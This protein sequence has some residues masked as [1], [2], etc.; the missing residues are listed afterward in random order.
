MIN[1]PI[2]AG[3]VGELPA[4]ENQDAVN[5]E[6]VAM[7]DSDKSDNEQQEIQWPIDDVQQNEANIIP[8]EEPVITK[9]EPGRAE[10]SEEEMTLEDIARDVSNLILQQPLPLSISDFPELCR[11]GSLPISLFDKEKFGFNTFL[12][13]LEECAEIEDFEVVRALSVLK[14]NDGYSYFAINPINPEHWRWLFQ[15][16]FFGEQ[17]D[18]ELINWTRVP[19]NLPSAPIFSGEPSDHTRGVKVEKPTLNGT[20][21]PI[22]INSLSVS[23]IANMLALSDRDLG[24]ETVLKYDDEETRDES[25][26]PV[27]PES[28]RKKRRRKARRI[29]R[30]KRTWCFKFQK[31]ECTDQNCGFIHHCS[32]CRSF[33]HGG[34]MCPKRNERG[35]R[36]RRRGG[37]RRRRGKQF[38]SF[39]PQMMVKPGTQAMRA[40]GPTAGMSGG[41]IQR[42]GANKSGARWNPY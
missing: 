38:Q 22:K 33:E 29:R 24:N 26:G 23:E 2:I 35:R 10:L 6:Q 13:M 11:D 15:T 21:E 31:G 41:K 1:E 4:V 37:R 20:K 16:G 5:L 30:A 28:E 14:Q 27:K 19:R 3:N 34:K 7:V 25:E 36:R 18:K 39:P 32:T 17:E 42:G 12:E 9:D 8:K 40:G